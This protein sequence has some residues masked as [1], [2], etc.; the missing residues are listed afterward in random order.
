MT[1]AL[2]QG[3]KGVKRRRTLEPFLL[4]VQDVLRLQPPDAGRSKRLSIDGVALS[5]EPWVVAC[6]GSQEGSPETQTDRFEL[7]SQSLALWLKSALD[8]RSLRREIKNGSSNLYEEQAKLMLDSAFG[9]GL[10]Q[11][12][13]SCVDGLVRQGDFEEAK[14]LSKFRGQVSALVREVKQVI[15]ESNAY[16]APDAEFEIETPEEIPATP[17]A[18]QAAAPA[19]VATSVLREPDPAIRR[20]VRRPRPVPAVS[21]PD[22]PGAKSSGYRTLILFVLDVAALVAWVLLTMPSRM[23]AQV[24]AALGSHDFE[25]ASA[26]VEIVARPP[27]LYAS[28]DQKTWSGYDPKRQ[29]RFVD[30]MGNVLLTH[31]YWGLL[32]KTSDGRLVG[33]WHENGGTRLLEPTP[34]GPKTPGHIAGRYS[35][36]VP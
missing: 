29:R 7:L 33:E 17:A 20:P 10:L 11:D 27:A 2:V 6:V 25:N 35:R 21:K 32:L 30:S 22:E 18:P 5:L 1:E 34:Q 8:V 3:S 24:P 15:A 9:A 31:G 36:F 28:V 14:R 26:L 12:L 19:A 16:S 13:Q 4:K 23:Q